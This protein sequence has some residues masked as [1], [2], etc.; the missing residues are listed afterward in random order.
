MTIDYLGNVIHASH[1]PEPDGDRLYRGG[2]TCRRCCRFVAFETSL[3]T[4]TDAGV[5][6]CRRGKIELRNGQ[7]LRWMRV[8]HGRVMHA[9]EPGHSGNIQSIC[10]KRDRWGKVD[11]RANAPVTDWSDERYWY[12]NCRH[13]DKALA[14][15]ITST[16]STPVLTDSDESR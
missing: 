8:E 7:P 1:D 10:R 3:Y 16:P 2:H 13:C 5:A 14:A 6:E 11:P 9:V 4:V 15:E 12:P